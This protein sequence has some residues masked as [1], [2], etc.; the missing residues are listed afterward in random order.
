MATAPTALGLSPAFEQPAEVLESTRRA[1][2]YWPLARYASTGA[3]R[4]AAGSPSSDATIVP[5]WFRLDFAIDGV[6]EVDGADEILHNP[7]FVD[8]A[9]RVYG[10]E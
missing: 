2:P 5:P 1:G 10:G 4:E 8:A 6:A 7:R 9:R 3:A